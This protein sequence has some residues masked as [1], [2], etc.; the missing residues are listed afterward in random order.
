MKASYVF[1]KKAN[2]DIDDIF[3]YTIEKWSLEQGERYFNHIMNEVEYLTANFEIGQDF[4]H[5][6]KGY[7]RA[8]V[9]S[10]IIFYKINDNGIIEI[11][12]ILHQMMDIK[13]RLK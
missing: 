7:R 13:K 11:V 9:K 8:K 3:L 2:Q 12:R 10:H 1:S 6:R 5:I 4:S